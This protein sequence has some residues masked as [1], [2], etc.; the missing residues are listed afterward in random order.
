ML[1]PA[2]TSGVSFLK[3]KLGEAVASAASGAAE[4]LNGAAHDAAKEGAAN[5][6]QNLG[7]AIEKL[8]GELAENEKVQGAIDKLGQIASKPTADKLKPHIVVA[9]VAAIAAIAVIVHLARKQ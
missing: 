3:S 4:G 7:G 8:A 2:I 6:K 9:T 1:N 5:V